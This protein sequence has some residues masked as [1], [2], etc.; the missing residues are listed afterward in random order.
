MDQ[1]LREFVIR[2]AFPSE[3][4]EVVDFYY[5]MI[6]EP[7]DREYFPLWTK[8]V[9][10]A[11]EAIKSAVRD[12]R[13]H[14]GLVDGRIASS[15]VLGGNDETYKD[16][17]WP[18]EA[19]DDEVSVI[20]LLAVHGDFVRKG[21][22]KRM[23]EYAADVS[24]KMGRKVIRLDVLNGNFPAENLYTACG[25]IYAGSR[26]IFYEDTGLAEFHLYEMVL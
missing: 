4:D 15:M 16:F 1:D 23:V 2:K 18:A 19:D 21:F 25:F 20:H 22:A 7:G 6:D 14:L 24:R 12:G 11:R 17:P 10:P 8:D 9:Y 26:E 5:N 13:M 3:Q